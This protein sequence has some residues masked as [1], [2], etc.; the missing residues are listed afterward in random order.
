MRHAYNSIDAAQPWVLRGTNQQT[1]D[2][3]LYKNPSYKVHPAGGGTAVTKRMPGMALQAFSLHNRSAGAVTVGIGVRIPN[4]L[5]IAGQYVD[6]TTTY[7]DKTTAA[8]NTTTND[9]T[10][11]TTT[12]DD[13]FIIA[14]RVPFNAVSVNVSTASVDG[15]PVRATSFSDSAGTAW[16]TAETNLFIPP[17][18]GAV[19]ATGEMVIAFAA[20]LDWGKSSSLATGLPNGYYAMNVQSTTAP[21]TTAAIAKSIEIF[22]LFYLVEALAD[23][24]VADKDFGGGEFPMAQ[25]A[26]EGY[27]GDALVALFSTANDQNRV[28]AAV[29]SL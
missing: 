27:Y 20:P 5:W 8:Q 16:Q 4:E 18:T 28:T 12:N 2:G 29:R 3:L 11:E 22:R 15:T 7:T 6:A 23:N 1:D 13:G 24:S 14:S 17:T 19:Y 9:I 10:L 26:V 21:T 25:D